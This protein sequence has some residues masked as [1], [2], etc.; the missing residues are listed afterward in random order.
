MK[1]RSQIATFSLAIINLI[2]FLAFYILIMLVVYSKTDN[3]FLNSFK[4]LGSP[5][6]I[7]EFWLY[8]SWIIFMILCVILFEKI[9]MPNKIKRL[10]F[11]FFWSV[12]ILTIIIIFSTGFITM[13][14]IAEQFALATIIAMVIVIG[15]IFKLTH[16]KIIS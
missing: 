5:I 4:T 1:K 10:I 16:K 12:S 3:E 11:Y 15:V 14:G 9:T 2:I 7:L 6:I 13:W 8:L